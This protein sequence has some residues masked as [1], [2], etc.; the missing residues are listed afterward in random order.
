MFEAQL[1]HIDYKIIYIYQKLR[2]V[3]RRGGTLSGEKFFLENPKI[4]AMRKS[5]RTRAEGGSDNTPAAAS[6]QTDKYGLS[7]EFLSE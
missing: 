1:L 7:K 5:I 6:S 4:R 2:R 3:G